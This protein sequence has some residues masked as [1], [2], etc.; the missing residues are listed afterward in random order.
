MMN[1]ETV[2]AV[3]D[4]TSMLIR[5]MTHVKDY[6]PYSRRSTQGKTRNETAK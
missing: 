2:T 3:I 5:Q 4:V 6:G 1:E